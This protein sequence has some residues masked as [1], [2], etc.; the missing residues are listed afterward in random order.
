MRRTALYYGG[1]TASIFYPLVV[2]DLWRWTG[3]KE[4]VRPFNRTGAQRADLG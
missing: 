1:V 4:R 3:D 2:A